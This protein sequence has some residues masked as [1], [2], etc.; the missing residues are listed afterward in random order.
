MR[1]YEFAPYVVDRHRARD[2]DCDNGMREE[3]AA[4]P[5][6]TTGSAARC[7]AAAATA[8]TATAATAWQRARCDSDA[9]AGTVGATNV[10]RPG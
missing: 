8:S 3:S 7:C 5:A 9:R 4:T 10:S 6:A 1:L 2:G